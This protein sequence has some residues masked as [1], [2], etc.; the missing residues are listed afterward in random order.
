MNNSKSFLIHW[1]GP[2]KGENSLEDLKDWESTQNIEPSLYLIKGYKKYAKITNHF[3]IGKTI[4]GVSKRFANQGHHINESS[5]KNSMLA[6]QFS[7]R[8]S[9]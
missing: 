3:Y 7:N 2:F 1:Y 9:R 6:R 5:L 4:Q 8:E